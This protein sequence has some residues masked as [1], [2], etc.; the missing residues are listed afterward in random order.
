MGQRCHLLAK[1]RNYRRQRENKEFWKTLEE[2]GVL[3]NFCLDIVFYFMKSNVP[4]S[5]YQK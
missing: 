4:I 3:I 1:L 5:Y 2:I